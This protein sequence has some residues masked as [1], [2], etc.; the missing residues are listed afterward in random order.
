MENKADS[1]A[2]LRLAMAPGLGPRGARL[3]REI[4]LEEARTLDS[5]LDEPRERLAAIWRERGGES[6]AARLDI[7]SRAQALETAAG[8]E[9]IGAGW[10]SPEDSLFPRRLA[11]DPWLD[12][13]PALFWIGDLD[14]LDSAPTAIGFSGPTAPS[15]QGRQAARQLARTLAAEGALA[16]SGF[17]R[18]I[19]WAAHLGALEG[20]GATAAM[21][22]MG[23]ASADLSARPIRDALARGRFV[24]ISPWRPDAPWRPEYA[25]RRNAW[26]AAACDA[27]AVGELTAQ[28]RGTANTIG[29]ARRRQRPIWAFEHPPAHAASLANGELIRSGA[30]SIRVDAEG[31]PFPEDVRRE[32]QRIRS[33]ERRESGACGAQLRFG[34]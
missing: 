11:G 20:G 19:D 14:L 31:V 34:I 33:P 22:P 8:L 9:R 18:G 3:L 23:I 2:S 12:P 15:R 16:V 30:R 21:L 25:I 13:P 10:A 4:A 28:S 26:I 7:P 24:A 27:L 32:L 5:L 6:L 29:Q 1:L 17:A